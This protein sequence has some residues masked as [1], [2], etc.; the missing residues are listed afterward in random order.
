MS[1]DDVVDEPS[2][3]RCRSPSLSPRRRFYGDDDGEVPVLLWAPSPYTNSPLYQ[4]FGFGDLAVDPDEL[5]SPHGLLELAAAGAAREQW[6]SGGSA[7]SSDWSE[8]N[9]TPASQGGEGAWGEDVELRGNSKTRASQACVR[10]SGVHS[11]GPAP[12]HEQF[13]EFNCK[14]TVDD[15]EILHMIGEGG[16]GKVYQVRQR[17]RSRQDPSSGTGRILAMKCMRKEAVL[18]DNLKGTKNER[19][20]L[21]R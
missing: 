16:F 13:Q 18:Q 8:S 14:V 1:F 10:K 3:S 11:S 5:R 9:G 2:R 4:G 21:S 15:F 17:S 7:H 20:I 6:F 12:A 19:S